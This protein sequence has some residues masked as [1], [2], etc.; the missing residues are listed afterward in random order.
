MT[1]A[2]WFAVAGLGLLTSVGCAQNGSLGNDGSGAPVSEGGGGQSGSLSQQEADSLLFMREEE[3]LARDVYRS[4]DGYGNPFV[5][6]Q[7]SEQNHMDALLGLL[8]AYGLADPVVSDEVGSFANQELK[9]LYVKLV[10]QGEP[11]E[12]AALSVGCTIEELDIRDIERAKEDVTHDDVIAT[13]DLL[14]LGSRNHLRAFYGKL[15]QRGG[16][17]TPQYIDQTEFDAI[18]NSS[19]ERPRG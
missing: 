9:A 10:E 15:K 3:K 17:Y 14:L 7:G 19:R 5:N 4:L 1:L 6:I 13:Y 8:D 2:G 11:S 18:V 16:S 12:L